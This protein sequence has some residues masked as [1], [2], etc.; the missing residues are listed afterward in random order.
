MVNGLALISAVTL[1][2]GNESQEKGNLRWLLVSHIIL[3]TILYAS[4]AKPRIQV[5]CRCFLHSGVLSLW[6]Q[7]IFTSQPAGVSIPVNPPGFQSPGLSI[8][9]SNF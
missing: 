5:F 1:H 7:L 8:S 2:V 4:K 3:T 6:L 9:C